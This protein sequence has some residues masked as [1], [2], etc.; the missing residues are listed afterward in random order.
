[1]NSYGMKPLNSAVSSTFTWYNLRINLGFLET[2][3]L[4]LPYASINTYFS[5][6]AKCCFRGGVGRQFP[7]NLVSIPFRTGGESYGVTEFDFLRRFEA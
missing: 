1:M 4:P 6:G 2:A 7:K 5:F 3:H